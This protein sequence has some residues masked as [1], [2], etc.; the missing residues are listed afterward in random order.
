MKAIWIACALALLTA[1][2]FASQSTSSNYSL[3]NSTLGSDTNGQTASSTSYSLNNAV[4]GEPAV[5]SATSSSYG[6]DFGFLSNNPRTCAQLGGNVCDSNASCSGSWL[7]ASDSMRCCSIACTSA[8]STPTTT[9]SGGGGSGT[10]YR[11]PAKKGLG[12]K[13]EVDANCSS[14]ICANGYCG[15]CRS[16]ETCAG[17]QYCSAFGLCLDVQ[18]GVCGIAQNHVWDSFECCSNAYCSEGQYCNISS[19]SCADTPYPRLFVELSPKQPL[20][21]KPFEVRVSRG[22][23]QIVSD[24]QIQIDNSPFE[25]APNGVK[26]FSLEAGAHVVRAKKEGFTGD[27]FEFK[28]LKELQVVVPES[29]SPGELVAVTI[30]DSK[31]M[32]VS[33]AEILLVLPDGTTRTIKT[34]A[35]GVAFVQS[36]L[37]GLLKMTVSSSGFA[38]TEKDLNVQSSQ[39]P[40]LEWVIALLLLLL[41]A[42]IAWSTFSRKKAPVQKVYEED[43]IERAVKEATLIVERERKEIALEEKEKLLAERESRELEREREEEGREKM[44]EGR[45]KRELEREK[46]LEA[47]AQKA[48]EIEEKLE[49]EQKRI[50]HEEKLLEEEHEMLKEMLD[51]QQK[52][53]LESQYS[54][55]PLLLPQPPAQAPSEPVKAEE[56]LK[57][58]PPKEEPPKTEPPKEEPPK[59]VEKPAVEEKSKEAEKKPAPKEEDNKDEQS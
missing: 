54:S 34:N 45:E 9:P 13:C 22:A 39:G 42:L 32:P 18:S 33:G 53:K 48:E 41:V 51:E 3:E 47:R 4:V 38:A 31:G 8:P 50:E 24:I 20:E 58:E 30:L 14:N 55:E 44:E 40:G 6:G 49:E 2:A 19:H 56:P 7:D 36:E 46:E 5:G 12:E 10:V 15:E 29:A 23:G 26:T 17:T 37:V 52:K 43:A 25:P 16:S 35:Q 28:V 11:P 59:A 1:L 27:A 21:G 57:E